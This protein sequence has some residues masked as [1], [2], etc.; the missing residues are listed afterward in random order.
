MVQFHTPGSGHQFYMRFKLFHNKERH[1]VLAFGNAHSTVFFWDLARLTEFHNFMAELNRPSREASFQRPSWLQPVVH[2][3][4]AGALSKLRGDAEDRDSVTSGRTGSD[5]EHPVVHT[6]QHNQEIHQ[7]NQETL[8]S[9]QSKYDLTR[10]DEAIKAHSQSTITIKDFIGRQV[11][12]SPLGD[13]CVVVGSKN[14][15][16]ILARWQKKEKDEKFSGH[17]GDLRANQAR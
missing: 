7:Y 12:W 6:N 9:W 4:K 11:A 17:W 2:R 3:Q 14:L 1:P 10:V 8:D 16:V 15:A 5:V 13:W